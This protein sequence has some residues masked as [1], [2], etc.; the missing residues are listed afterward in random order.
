MKNYK[1]FIKENKTEI[2]LEVL[3]KDIISKLT[4]AEFNK[5]HSNEDIL[6]MIKSLINRGAD[7]NTPTNDYCYT[8]LIVA[9][10]LNFIDIVKLL[11]GQPDIDINRQN[12]EGC[13]ALIGAV[14]DG[15]SD[16]AKLLIT[17]PEIDVTLKCYGWRGWSGDFIDIVVN[18]MKAAY[19]ISVKEAHLNFLKEY[20]LQKKIINNGREDIILFLNKYN[21]YNDKIK[22]EYPH[23]FT[24]SELNLL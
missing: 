20:P 2:P 3:W 4:N 13:T 9:S 8:L 24:G 19:N 12:I 10:C 1:R 21:I 22:N 23:L 15:R 6:N 11:L 14:V 7:V 16:I 17:R 18:G 5:Y